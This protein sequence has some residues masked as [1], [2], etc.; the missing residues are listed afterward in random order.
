MS[1]Q[2]LKKPSGT[3]SPFATSRDRVEQE[4]MRIGLG[5]K[6]ARMYLAALEH[7]SGTV[8]ALAKRAGFTRS[9]AYFVIETLIE[10]GLMTSVERDEK[11]H[12]TAEPPSRLELLVTREESRIAEMRAVFQ[13]LMPE[14]A[15]LLTS[16]REQPRVRFYE[17][18]EGLEAMRSD[19]FTAEKKS[20]LLL[21]SAADDYHR[22][23]GLARRLPHAQRMERTRGFE[24]CIFTSARPRE[25][26]RKTVPPI[27]RVERYR[28]PEKEYP[29]AG[30]IAVY[31]S[32]LA[33]LTYRGKVMGVLVESPYL[34]QTATTL[35]NLAWETVKRYEKFE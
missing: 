23:V 29:L 4:L 31:G 33:L 22:I 28:I 12:F 8:I 25:E 6:E 24:R 11:K 35:F 15:P 17:G 1:K 9:T 21:I 5:A 13:K 18:I 2:E 26:L 10:H 19:F 30:E 27:A 20:E 34:A 7:G 32:K 3:T 14:L 16:S